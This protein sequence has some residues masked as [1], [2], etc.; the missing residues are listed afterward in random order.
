MSN[1]CYDITAYGAVKDGETLCTAAVQRAI[2]ECAANGGGKVIVP[3]GRYRVGTVY[4]RDN[5]ELHLQTGA[6]LCASENLDDYNPDDA[7]PQNHGCPAEEWNAKHLVIAHAVRNVAITGAGTIDGSAAAFFA[8]PEF[9]RYYIWI[10]GLAL[11]K[12]KE[13]LRPGQMV[14]FI[15]CKDVRVEDVT[16][17]NAT[18]WACFFH[19]CDNVA[20]RGLK[21]FNP[22]T[23]ANTDGI[24]IDCCSHVA[25]R[26][27]EIDT[28]DDAIAIRADG[29]RLTDPH[30]PCEDITVTNCVLASASS[31]FRIG[32]GTGDI[33]RVDISHI[34]VKS[35][36]TCLNLMS[37][38]PGCDTGIEDIRVRDITAE[39][40]AHPIEIG[41]GREKGVRNVIIENFT[42]HAA[43]N[44][45]IRAAENRNVR[46]IVLRNIEIFEANDLYDELTE[47]MLP[48]RGRAMFVLQ[49]AEDVTLDGVAIRADAATAATWDAPMEIVNCEGL[50]LRDVT[51]PQK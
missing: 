11:S 3:A 8:P 17:Q 47:A 27:C 32:V 50:V 33:R 6:V 7:Y 51:L 22:R 9:Y 36:A 46:G 20:V 48:K 35:G 41:G 37:D 24:D 18:C 40:I 1:G 25:I 14:V 29:K 15:E 42:V 26:D 28:G 2:D 4:L 12:D 43:A 30:K 39:K 16:L 49:N 45:R 44:C 5:V 10:E 13:R 31:V 19:G 34:T 23:H 38:W 21:V